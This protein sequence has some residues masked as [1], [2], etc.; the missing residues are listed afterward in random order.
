MYKVIKHKIAHANKFSKNSFAQVKN[1]MF[2]GFCAYWVAN[3]Q[4][5][6]FKFWPKF[7]DQLNLKK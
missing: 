3:F 2:L 4:C 1:L 6:N 7:Y 5:F